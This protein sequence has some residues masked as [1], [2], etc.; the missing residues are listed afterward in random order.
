[1]SGG[2][3]GSL[4][5]HLFEDGVEDVERVTEVDTVWTGQ[6]L[7]VVRLPLLE[8]VELDSQISVIYL[9]LPVKTKDSH[10]NTL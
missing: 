3:K 2:G 9:L 7:V 10:E 6:L 8:H 1:M 5:A 4:G